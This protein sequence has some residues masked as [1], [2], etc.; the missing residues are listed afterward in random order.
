MGPEGHPSSLLRQRQR[1]P[2]LPRALLPAKRRRL[3]EVS[4]PGR[5][6]CSTAPARQ[7]LFQSR[8]KLSRCPG[9]H[10]ILAASSDHV[11]GPCLG[12]GTFAFLTQADSPMSPSCTGKNEMARQ[13]AI[14]HQTEARAAEPC[15]SA[16]KCTEWARPKSRGSPV[17]SGA[18]ARAPSMVRKVPL[19]AKQVRLPTWRQCFEG[20]HQLTGQTSATIGIWKR[21]GQACSPICGT[22]QL[23]APASCWLAL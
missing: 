2:E 17:G 23:A 16:H 21:R 14:V 12:F 13:T 9:R 1:L 4:D 18:S 20:S 7:M 11:S 5:T 15:G 22:A 3:A 19:A 10:Q 8:G 6:L